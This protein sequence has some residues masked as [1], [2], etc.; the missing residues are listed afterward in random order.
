MATIK[1]RFQPHGLLSLGLLKQKVYRGQREKLI[2]PEL[3]RKIFESWQGLVVT[4]R[5][6][7][8]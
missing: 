2:E 5:E 1:S 7:I 6:L 8:N 4:N 3:K